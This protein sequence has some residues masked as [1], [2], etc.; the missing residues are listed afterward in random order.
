M[1][2]SFL[3]ATCQPGAERALKAEATSRGFASSFQRPG[4]VTFK[5]DG[6]L[7]VDEGLPS[8]FA[9]H[10]GLSLGKAS[11]SELP[12]R[13]LGADVA[14]R[15]TR[16][17]HVVSTLAD[18]D[19]AFAEADALRTALLDVTDGQFRKGEE[20]RAGELVA[21]VVLVDGEPWLSL[22]RHR[23]GR[24][25]FPGGRMRPVLPPTAPSRAWLKLEEA[26]RV[27]DLP[28]AEGQR[29]LELGSAPGGAT[30]SLLDR[31]LAVIGV[32]PN[33]MDSAVLQ[34]PKFEHRQ[35]TSMS[36]DPVSLPPLDWI[37]LD[38]NVPPGTALRGALPFVAAHRRTLKGIVFTLKMKSWDIAGEV[39]GWLRRIQAAHP[40]LRL[41]ARQLSSNGQEIC[42]VGRAVSHEPA[43]V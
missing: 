38:V 16:R 18:D 37:L 40:G 1:V 6:V 30:R 20:P 33:E 2:P 7:D 23:V 35:A 21:T 19:Q 25:P 34:H 43:K 15:G 10:A 11:S 14:G 27:F 39:N 13:L 42:V 4:F 26:V 8:I 24:S 32:D 36:V 12:A 29:A 17:L 22:H 3:L 5:S 9:R 28:F 41:E 31:G